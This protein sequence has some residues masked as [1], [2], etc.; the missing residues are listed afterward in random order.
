MT[1]L[2]RDYERWTRLTDRAA[3]GEPLSDE[4]QA[5]VTRFASEH[6][7][8]RSEEA[9]LEAL[10]A[11]DARPDAASG[12][13]VDRVLADLDAAPASAQ[14]AARM[15]PARVTTLRPIAWAA[16]LAAAA[17]V[18]LGLW[19]D[20]PASPA[21]RDDASA[22]LPPARVELV[23]ASGPVRVN[24]ARA[25]VSPGLL[26]EGALLEAGAGGACVALDPEIDVCLGEHSQARLQSI[27]GRHRALELVRGR[28]AAHLGH[29]P[30]GMTFSIVAG[31]VWSTAVGTKFS[32]T[33]APEGV[34]TTVLEG[35]VRVGPRNAGR[36]VH[37]HQQSNV[38]AQEASLAP[39]SRAAEASEWALLEPTSLWHDRV[40]ATL[41]LRGAPD[42]ASV[43]LDERAIGIAPLAS[44]IPVGRH[45]LK[46]QVAGVTRME[47]SFE[48]GAGETRVIEFVTDA[49]SAAPVAAPEPAPAPRRAQPAERVAHAA[50]EVPALDPGLLL[51]E[52][53][54]A[55]REQQWSTA[56]YKYEQLV[57]RFA[58]TA[59]AHT[60][61]VPL[62]QLQLD[63]LSR[64][65]LA[66]RSLDRYLA[67]G[68]GNLAQEARHSRIRALRELGAD[69]QE[70]EAI[71]GYLSDY[72]TSFQARSLEKRLSELRP[73]E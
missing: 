57:T 35:A 54:R 12:L 14:R 60:V 46:V 8:A 25:T 29:Q 33:L 7:A 6:P 21:A 50:D 62:G 52:A 20:A 51:E 59:E 23:Y 67:G 70:V 61:L 27:G 64:A 36:L 69:D 1:D 24:G 56:A 44:L 5:F 42:G 49:A 11:L 37:A 65:D 26:G 22:N 15:G 63:H 39:I 9:V 55:L 2:P 3:R 47:R 4:E 17:V 10:G 40:A 34:R 16:S 73:N 28:V 68:G 53:R 58:G 71:R 38:L 31:G 43:T 45:V 13:L 19:R 66:L 41:E 48:I 72:P 18:G 30:E 32:V